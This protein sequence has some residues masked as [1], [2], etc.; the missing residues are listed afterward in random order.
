MLVTDQPRCRNISEY[1]RIPPRQHSR[2]REKRIC[3]WYMEGQRGTPVQRSNNRR[4]GRRW[5]TKDR[6]KS[7]YGVES[8]NTLRDCNSR[9]QLDPQKVMAYSMEIRDRDLKY[10]GSAARSGPGAWESRS[11]KTA[12]RHVI[13]WARR[14]GPFASE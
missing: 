5:I 14:D 1:I 11:N 12:Y 6:E 9:S 4:E 3:R 13:W 2:Y 7:V 10:P 8:T